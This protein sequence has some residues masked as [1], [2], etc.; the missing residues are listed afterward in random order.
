[1]VPSEA[2]TASGALADEQL[3]VAL[4]Q[5]DEGAFCALV[6]RYHRSMVRVALSFV[7]SQAVAEEV[8]QDTWMA[9]LKGVDRF[10]GRSSLRTWIFAVLENRAR[11]S[12]VRERRSTPFSSLEAPG[13][14]EGP[15]VDPSRFH[16]REEPFAGYWTTAPARWSELPD[17]KLLSA[18]TRDVV[19]DAIR[20]LPTRQRQVVTLRDVEGWSSDEVCNLLGLSESNQRV[21]LHRARGRVRAALEGHLS[22]E[23]TS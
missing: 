19:E 1:L 16:T 12:G 3:L 5:G 11:S 13:E 15:T 8:V 17:E 22:P 20:A 23:G 4:R 14:E 2:A 18:E 7:P 21:L 10:E 6:G 9:V